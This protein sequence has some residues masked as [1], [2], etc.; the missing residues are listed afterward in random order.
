MFLKNHTENVVEKLVADPLKISKLGIFLDQHS[1]LLK[2]CL[3][4]VLA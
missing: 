3:L 4:Y 2:L 1:G